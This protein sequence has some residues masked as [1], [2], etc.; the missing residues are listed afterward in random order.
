MTTDDATVAGQPE[1]ATAPRKIVSIPAFA[2][3][4]DGYHVADADGLNQRLIA[5]V[6]AWRDADPGETSSN[7][8]GWHSTR[9]IF[10]RPERSFQDLARHVAAALTTSIRRYW[11]QYDPARHGTRWEGWANVN[12]PGATNTPHAHSYHLAGVYY[13]KVPPVM[14]SREGMIEFLNPM[15]AITRSTP[16]DHRLIHPLLHLQPRAGQMFFFPSY[17]THWVTPHFA[18]EERISIAF[19]VAVEDGEKPG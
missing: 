1:S 9:D 14:G 13:V 3:Y 11:P 18:E 4:I 7:H 8:H 6:L 12:G 5:D 10:S 2:S 19:N 17:L 16:F 15:G